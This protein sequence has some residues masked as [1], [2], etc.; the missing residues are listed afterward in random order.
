MMKN[1]V[2]IKRIGTKEWTQIRRGVKAK[3]RGEKNFDLI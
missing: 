2:E 1:V 3:Q